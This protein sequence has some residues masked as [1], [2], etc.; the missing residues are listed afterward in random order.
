MTYPMSP[1]I[2][3]TAFPRSSTQGKQLVPLT[4]HFYLIGAVPVLTVLG[5]SH[6]SL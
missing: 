1:S 6:S 5:T 2:F 4:E 3:G